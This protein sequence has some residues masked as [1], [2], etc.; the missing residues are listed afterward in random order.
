MARSWN[1]QSL[2][3]IPG[4]VTSRISYKYTG[5]FLPPH[6]CQGFD[7]GSSSPPAP[8]CWLKFFI[9]ILNLSTVASVLSNNMKTLAS[10][11][12]RSLSGRTRAV[13]QTMR[14]RRTPEMLIRIDLD[15]DIWKKEK[16]VKKWDGC[17]HGA[18]RG[19]D[20]E[21]HKY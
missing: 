12:A 2:H 14:R 20:S 10:L 5:R 16:K 6:L 7:S 1:P 9:E 19:A 13:Q 18:Q 11:C 3:I 4:N 17:C 21:R 8:H 15:V